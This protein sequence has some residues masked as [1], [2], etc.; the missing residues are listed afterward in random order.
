LYQSGKDVAIIQRRIGS[1]LKITTYAASS[2]GI[3]TPLLVHW[4]EGIVARGELRSQVGHLIDVM[5]T[6]IE[7][8]G[9][10]YPAKAGGQNIPTMEGKSLVPAFVGRP[11]ER[12]LLAWEH[13]RNRAIRAGKWKLVALHDKP[14]QLYDLEADRTELNDLA[15]RM[16]DRVKELAAQWEQWAKRTNVLPYPDPKGSP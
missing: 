7:V 8:S 10:R 5:A 13:E 11:V 2:C 6:F 15:A 12:P 3:A 16:S 1:T 4:P 9:A 14:W